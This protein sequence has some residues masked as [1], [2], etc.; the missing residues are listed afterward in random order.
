MSVSGVVEAQLT[1]LTAGHPS[2]SG[3]QHR[4]AVTILSYIIVF[5]L[6]A[7]LAFDLWRPDVLLVGNVT[8]DVLGSGQKKYRAP[9]G[10]H[11]PGFKEFVQGVAM[12]VAVLHVVSLAAL[13]SPRNITSSSACK[14]G[15]CERWHSGHNSDSASS[16][17]SSGVVIALIAG[18]VAPMK[19]RCV[20]A[21]QKASWA[22]V[23]R[24]QPSPGVQAL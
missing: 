10:E 15:A 11:P 8:I 7:F 18:V 19:M 12:F 23:P 1:H 22:S 24:H 2:A 21:S 6:A 16:D 14:V 4:V 20:A 3:M 17:D 9:G 13:C 5:L